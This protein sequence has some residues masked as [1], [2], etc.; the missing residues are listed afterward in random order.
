MQFLL[1]VMQII[2]QNEKTSDGVSFMTKAAFSVVRRLEKGRKY[3][4]GKR[5][6]TSSKG[7]AAYSRKGGRFPCGRE[8]AFCGRRAVASRKE[9][10]FLCGGRGV[11]LA[12][13][14][15]F[16]AGGGVFFHGRRVAGCTRAAACV[17]RSRTRVSCGPEAGR[18]GGPHL[19][20]SRRMDWLLFADG[21]G[22]LRGSKAA[23]IM[24]EMFSGGS[25]RR[26][27]E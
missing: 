1:H 12:E 24:T 13:G 9:G 21:G 15:T 8:G 10:S 5:G 3:R 4:F 2:G 27:R 16:F 11:F 22:E 14:R 20:V 18:G 23:N 26:P 7:R 6:A 25:L 19:F 17:G